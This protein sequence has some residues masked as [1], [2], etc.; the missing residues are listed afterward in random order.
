MND[1]ITT[2]AQ[3]KDD[4]IDLLEL[5]STILNGKWLILGVTLLST[6]LA[7]IYAFGQ[8]P[9]YKADV[10][11]QVESESSGV[12]GL[13]DLAG[14]GAGEDTSV[15]TELEIIKSRKILGEAVKELKLDITAQPKR[16]PLLGNTYKHLFNQNTTNKPPLVGSGYAWGSESIQISR[17]E[18]SK[19]LFNTPLT[20]IKTGDSTFKL[21]QNDKELLSGEIGKFVTSKNNNVGINVLELKAQ[22]KTKF[23]IIKWSHLRAI[24]NLKKNLKASEKGK[25]TG[26]VTL[27]LQGSNKQLIVKTLDYI[28]KT[29]L[30]QNK[31]RSSEEAINA[32]IFLEEQIK[33][34]REKADVAEAAIKHYRTT[35]KTADMSMETQAVLKVVATIDTELQHLYLKRDELNQRFKKNHPTIQALNSQE[36]RL[37]K[38]KEQTLSKISELPETQQALLKLERDYKVA[39][40]IYTD[41][42]NN[43]QE[44]KIAKASSVGN[45][46]IID[47]AVAHDNPVKPKKAM[48]LAL[49]TLLGMMLGTLLVFIRKALHQTVNNPEKLGSV[50]SIPVYATVPLTKAVNI[51]K[52]IKKHKQQKSLLA[53]DNPTDP[54]IESLR[55]LRTSLHFALLEAKNN[56]VMITGPS[57]SIGKSFIASNF[58]A[59]IAA[60][61]QRVLLIDADMRKG[62]LHNLLNKKVSPGLSDLI[63][64]KVTL[65][66]TTHTVETGES[67]FDII[68]RGQTPP[69]PSELLMHSRFEELLNQLSSQYDLIVIDTPPVHAVTDPTIIGKHS[70]VVFMVVRYNQ[71]SMKEIEH[72]VARLAHTEIE[73][74]GFIFNAYE[75]QKGGGYGGYDY[76]SYYGDYKSDG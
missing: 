72:A 29:Y 14:F 24:E 74:K 55:S 70:G 60:S 34:V 20:L 61:E 65:E 2:K 4:E 36:D 31:S 23:T 13:Q 30:Q 44:F 50:T 47:T 67:T 25:K 32:L 9:I 27:V 7:L 46:Y 62:Y 10:L 33:P 15:G 42:L 37:E 56:I 52:G 58:S 16:V 5:L 6:L 48:I 51:T 8:Q 1:Q 17:L 43:I 39:N 68:T 38:R 53:I 64:G 63:S 26:I 11:L 35:N 19:G 75:A 54:A 22:E 57:P 49:G 45:V 73:T 41:L 71:H 12:P 3:S 18:V 66:E 69:N 40:S 28:S 76:H 59:V 21:F